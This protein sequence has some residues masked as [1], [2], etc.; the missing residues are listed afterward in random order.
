MHRWY[1]F[2]GLVLCGLVGVAFLIGCRKERHGKVEMRHEEHHGEV[3]EE[4]P[5]EMVPE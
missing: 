4:R 3:H 1:R 2:V 5:G